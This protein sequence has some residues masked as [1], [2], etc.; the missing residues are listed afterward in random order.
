MSLERR[1]PHSAVQRSLKACEIYPNNWKDAA[2]DLA[3]WRWTLKE[4]SERADV[5]RHQKDEERDYRK[6]RSTTFFPG[7]RLTQWYTQPQKTLQHHQRLTRAH[8][9][10]LS[11]LRLPMMMVVIMMIMVIISVVMPSSKSDVVI[12]LK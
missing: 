10:C 12:F 5:K 11:R 2:C 8:K 1:V 9:L 3:C 4:V 7:P 6:K